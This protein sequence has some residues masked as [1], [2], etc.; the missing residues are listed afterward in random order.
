[1]R[2][3]KITQSITNRSDKSLEKYLHDISKEKLITPEEE[4]ELARRI[5]H[6]D[7]LALNKLIRSN[8][9]FVVSVAKQ[10]QNQGLP[11]IDLIN[12]G[13]LGL[14]KAAKKFDETKGFKFISYAVWWIRQSI[15]E[16]LSEKSRV[17]RIPLNQ[18]ASLGKINKVI[19]KLEQDLERPPTADEISQVLE[20]PEDRVKDTIKASVRHNSLDAPLGGDE[21]FSSMLDILSNPDLPSTDSNL[22]NE[23]LTMEIERILSTLDDRTKEI[24]RMFYGIGQNRPKSLD[25]IG[26]EMCITRERVRQLKERGIRR[27][28]VFSKRKLLKSYL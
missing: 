28:R 5:R 12:D 27:L 16:A 19:G 14:I 3:L 13:N 24:I 7:E 10:Y 1:M 25:E 4:M 23:S 20:I 21:E 11:L 22:M 6:G 26:R 2:Q 17:I 18:I 9:R 15:L 8:L